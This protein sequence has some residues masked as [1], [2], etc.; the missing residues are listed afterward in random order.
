MVL[1]QLC[2]QPH[3]RIH[4]ILK[5]IICSWNQ[6][7]LATSVN[8]NQCKL[9]T[10][11]KIG[12]PMQNWQEQWVSADWLGRLLP[13]GGDQIID[14]ELVIQDWLDS[15]V[16]MVGGKM[17]DWSIPFSRLIGL[18]GNNGW[19]L[20]DWLISNRQN[21]HSVKREEKALVAFQ[22]KEKDNK[23]FLLPTEWLSI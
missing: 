17:I 11:C 20:N 3:R 23:I 1:N 7:K 18:T 5:Q 9:A 6:C 21:M 13:V 22:E 14:L 12:N 8:W 10:L 4:L 15:L 16:T 2:F 19:W